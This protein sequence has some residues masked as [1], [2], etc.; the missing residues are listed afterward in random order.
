ML[1]RIVMRRALSTLIPPK[2]VSAKNL[3]SAPNAQRIAKVVDFY[4]SLP[5][6]PAKAAAPTGVVG[7]FKAKYFDGE[8][9]S[10]MPIVH[11]V[12]GIITLGYS[13]EYYFH[14]RHAKDG[15]HH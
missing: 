12:L 13:M 7:R 10:G 5:Q 1:E 8:N 14:L 9:A 11:L 15:S 6:G 4:K 2:V 3:G